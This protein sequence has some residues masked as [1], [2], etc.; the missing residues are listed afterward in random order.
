MYK[1][2]IYSSSVGSTSCCR[3]GAV[4]SAWFNTR[5]LDWIRTMQALHNLSQRQVRNYRNLC[6]VDGDLSDMSYSFDCRII[7]LIFPGVLFRRKDSA[8]LVV[9]AIVITFYF[10]QRGYGESVRARYS[11]I[12]GIGSFSSLYGES[13]HPLRL[14]LMFGRSTLVLYIIVSISVPKTVPKSVR[15]SINFR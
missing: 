10:P 7:L 2:Q 1:R 8:P 4:Q 6:A 13:R 3:M 11:C 12:P 9:E 15:Y 14:C 5:F